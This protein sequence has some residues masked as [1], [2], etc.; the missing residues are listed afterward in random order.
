MGHPPRHFGPG[1]E[2][3]P[4]TISEISSNTTSRSSWATRTAHDQGDFVLGHFAGR[5]SFWEL[6]QKFKDI[7]PSRRYH[8]CAACFKKLSKLSIHH[9]G[10]AA[11]RGQAGQSL[12]T[13]AATSLRKIW[14]APGLAITTRHWASSTSTPAVRLSKMGL[15]NR[16]GLPAPLAPLG[17][18]LC[19][20]RAIAGS[21]GQPSGS[22]RPPRPGSAETAL[23]VKSPGG[24][25]RARLGPTAAVAGLK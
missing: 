1:F 24:R 6:G 16:R 22:G 18:R 7:L 15:A 19:V 14:A 10:Q 13:R 3:W 8:A 12:A 17:L 25:R 9:G 2:C 4:E 5:F 20:L 21:S 11:Q 23:G